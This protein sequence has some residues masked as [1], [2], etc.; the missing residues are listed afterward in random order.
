LF[1][2]VEVCDCLRPWLWFSEFSDGVLF[3]DSLLLS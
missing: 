1:K 2:L 3:S